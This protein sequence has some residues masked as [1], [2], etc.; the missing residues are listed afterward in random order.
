M[1][2]PVPSPAPV[3]IVGP[4]TRDEVVEG[5]SVRPVPGGSALYVA[6]SCEAMGLAGFVLALAGED[7]DLSAL[8]PHEVER[9]A[10]STLTL[11]HD[12]AG[13]VR[14]QSLV[15]PPGRTLSPADAP[16]SWPEPATLILGPLLPDDVDVLAFVEEYP[17]AE[18]ALI[19]QGLQRAIL[20]DD[21]VAHRAQPSS[22][23]LDA[24]RPNVSVFLSEEEVGLWPSGALGHLAARC[25]RV[26]V[27]AGA[28]GARVITRT[29]ER[30][31]APFEAEVVDSTGAG[32]VF[33]AA[34][35]LGL[36]AGEEFAGQVAAACAA[37]ACEVRGPG[38]LPSLT[39]I[40]ARFGF[41]V[42]RSAGA[43]GGRLA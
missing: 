34:F 19:A 8:E 41:E 4:V 7:A 18:V 26:V 3:W 28:A 15:A 21:R 12:F 2:P 30:Q 22:V 27:T 23:L 9:V 33:A 16:P 37:V 32:D 31:I 29:G 25:A 35:I 1:V 5:D 17:G 42:P 6:R 13:G 39:E 10:A 43:E 20:P 11:R 36:R 14:Q 40:A 24:A 38:V